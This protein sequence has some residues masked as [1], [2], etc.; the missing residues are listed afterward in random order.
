MIH[1][2]DHPASC[3]RYSTVFLGHFFHV[4]K[5]RPRSIAAVHTLANEVSVSGPH[6]VT[7]TTS[8]EAQVYIHR[9]VCLNGNEVPSLHRERFE[10]STVPTNL[11]SEDLHGLKVDDNGGVSYDKRMR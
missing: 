9:I 1:L 3:S 4:P 8:E 6:S 7:R 10:E 11:V 2:S 5:R